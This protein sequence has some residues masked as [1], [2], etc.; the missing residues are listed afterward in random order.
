MPQ[1]YDV[2]F[3]TAHHSNKTLFWHAVT[4]RVVFSLINGLFPCISLLEPQQN[5]LIQGHIQSPAKHQR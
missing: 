2:R 1:Y 4:I 3:R 5:N